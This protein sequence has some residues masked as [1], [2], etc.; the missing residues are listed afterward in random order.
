[1][2]EHELFDKFC[3]E[4]IPLEQDL[5][6]VDEQYLAEYEHM[7]SD[8]LADPQENDYQNVGVVSFV[9]TRKILGNSVEL[10]WYVNVSDRFHEV[11]IILPKEH[12]VCC[13]GCYAYDEKPRIYVKGEWL[14][15][16]HARSFSVFSLVDAVGVKK[17][18]EDDKLTT[19]MLTELRDK[20][21]ELA[22]KN[23]SISFISF[24][25]SLL[26]KSN[27][28]VGA[29]DT[30]VTYTYNPEIFIYL[31]DQISTIYQECIGLPTYSVITQGQNLY[32]ND[33]L[34]HISESKN[35]I[36]LNSLGIPFAQLLDIEHT[37][38]TNIREKIHAPAEVYMDSQYY[39]S[40]NFSHD[41]D[42]HDQPKAEYKTKMVSKACEYYFNSCGEL[43]SQLN[44]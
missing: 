35:H 30:D 3:F 17:Y 7:M 5:Y 11:S 14:A 29:Y 15:S 26:L 24:A 33:A 22:A 20:I 4:E 10:S 2:F 19:E 18:L 44:K 27:W 8:F 31:A 12:F 32:Y 25:D 13:V 39:Y 37:A 43:L 21:D 28:Y 34:L 41:F 16:I 36:S 6:L 23:P 1:M 42:K 40:L 9:A 38:R